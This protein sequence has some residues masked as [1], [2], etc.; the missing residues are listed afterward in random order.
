VL[1]RRLIPGAAEG[2]NQVIVGNR[3]AESFGVFFTYTAF[4]LLNV[5]RAT[6]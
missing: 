2:D 3:R 5:A 6:V 1:N 4:I